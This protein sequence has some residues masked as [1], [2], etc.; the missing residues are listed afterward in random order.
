MA[1][2]SQLWKFLGGVAK[3]TVPVAGAGAAAGVADTSERDALLRAGALAALAVGGSAFA[4]WYATRQPA[5]PPSE[6]PG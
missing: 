5:K 6:P 4:T 1:I 2:G 3:T